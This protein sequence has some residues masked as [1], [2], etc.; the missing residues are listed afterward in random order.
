MHSNFSCNARYKL[1]IITQEGGLHL[2]DLRSGA[3][4]QLAEQVQPSSKLAVLQTSVL[5]ISQEGYICAYNEA[6]HEVRVV[7]TDKV[8]T[9]HFVNQAA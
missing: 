2:L 1:Y 3:C 6:R 9:G 4:K 5:F 7:G 8:M